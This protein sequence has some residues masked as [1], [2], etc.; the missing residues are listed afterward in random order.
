MALLIMN[1]RHIIIHSLQALKLL[2][3][4]PLTFQR[5]IVENKLYQNNSPQELEK[6]SGRTAIANMV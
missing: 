5:E 6:C 4:R 3:Q 1:V 2:T